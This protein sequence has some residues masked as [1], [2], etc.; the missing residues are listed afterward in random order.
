MKGYGVIYQSGHF[1]NWCKYWFKMTLACMGNRLL[2]ILKYCSCAF[3]M[4]VIESFP[5]RGKFVHSR[6]RMP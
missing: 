3:L 4:A 5:I 2:V 1:C 6:A